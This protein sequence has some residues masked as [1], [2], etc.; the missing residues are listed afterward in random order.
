M[1]DRNLDH[2]NYRRIAAA[3]RYLDE[4]WA[5]RPGLAQLARAAHL[6]PFHFNR[7]FRRWAGVTPKQYLQWLALD[8]AKH[9]LGAEGA[10]LLEATG[11]VGLSGPSRLHDLFVTLEAMTP[12]EWKSGGA[13]LEIRF[14]YAPSPFGPVLLARTARG[15]CHLSFESATG[16]GPPRELVARFPRAELRRDDEMARELCGTLWS[17][18]GAAHDQL[19]LRVR[20]TNFQVRVWQ[21]LLRAT[22]GQNT[23]TYGQIAAELGAPTA[24]RAVGGAVGDNPVGW[25]IPCHRVLA[26]G[27]ALG[28][29][30]WGPDRKRMMLAWEY[31]Q[32][33][34]QVA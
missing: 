19:T 2:R 22:A 23:V 7:L 9:A 28:G 3:I 26:R 12:G 6:S 24:S 13:G 1:N 8:A 11:S 20:G 16:G 14:G 31:A 10:S 33:R 27:P 25:L 34:R 4:H 30:R 18:N 15:L 21:A 17:G 32:R 5:E 29:Y